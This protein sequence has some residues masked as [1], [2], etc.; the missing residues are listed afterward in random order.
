MG[1][2]YELARQN[3]EDARLVMKWRNDPDTRK[4][5]F[6]SDEKVWPA[7]YKEYCDNYFLFPELPPLFVVDGSEKIGFLRFNRCEDPFDVKRKCCEIS[8]NI[9][10]EFRGKGIGKALLVEI[11]KWVKGQG[12]DDLYAE[13]KN[14]NL[15]SH[16]AFLKAGFI[17]ISTEE[18]KLFATGEKI[19]TSRYV[20]KLT[21]FKN[22]SVT[23]IAEAGSNWSVG[24]AK[25]NLA[26]AKI[27]IQIAKEAGADIVKF[28]VFKP[29]LLYV[30]NAGSSCYLKSSGIEDSMSDLFK[31][32]AMP[33]AMI[34]ELFDYCQNIGIEFMATPF[35]EKDFFAVDP[36]VS[37]HKIASYELS[38]I[39]LLKLAAQSQKP[40]Y[41]STGAA[42]EEEIAWAVKAFY[43][44]GGQNLTLLQCTAAYPAPQGAMNL[45]AIPWLKERFKVPSGLSDHSED[46]VVAPVAAVALGACAIEKHFTLDKRLPGPDHAFALSPKELVKMVSAI[47]KASAMRG[48]FVKIVADEEK[49]LR[50]FAR[51]GLQAIKAIAPGDIFKEN[52]NIAILRPG[53][54]PL[55]IHPKFLPTIEG[56]IAT[57]HIEMG[58][59]I[60]HG[61]FS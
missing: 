29:E 58:C 36:F 31:D 22:D 26:M 34:E 19:V 23:I 3:E 17:K 57:R 13:V 24:G 37:R 56:K 42:T 15:F 7:F 39:H 41:L 5:S 14:E 10:S 49:E 55:G 54:F 33:Y 61:D 32:L 45:Q 52:E 46:P 2:A 40:L 9:A 50:D 48:A 53:N 6:H 43:E 44:F 30:S 59:G 16:K 20:A 11:Q 21:E 35:S 28:Q 1:L 8:I 38:H 4:N 47:R 51:R 12:Y 60:M 27:L 25:Q 18:K